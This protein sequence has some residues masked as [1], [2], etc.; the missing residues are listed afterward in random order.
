MCLEALG[1]R[2]HYTIGVTSVRSLQPTLRDEVPQITRLFASDFDGFP[3]SFR[4]A[5]LSLHNLVELRMWHF[6][7]PRGLAAAGMGQSTGWRM[8]S[9][10]R[11]C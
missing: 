7:H 1:K 11:A 6:I 10:S 5:T 4:I 8:R 2:G 3:E 9:A